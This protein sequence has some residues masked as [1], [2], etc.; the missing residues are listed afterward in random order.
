L[1]IATFAEL[2]PE[3]VERAHRMV[4]CAVATVDRRGRP[5]TRVLHPLWEAGG[6]WITTYRDSPKAGHL[7]ATP[8]ASLAYVAD[9]ARPA[10]AD[11]RAEWVDDPGERRRVWELFAATPPPL[12]FDPVPIYGSPQHPRF[13]LLRLVPWR[14]K[15]AD[16]SGPDHYRI[17]VADG[18][19]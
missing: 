19:P 4:W 18:R 2:E 17:W 13:G 3:L 14:V 10:Y 11:C 1:R 8:Y 9:V 12:G 16:T 15:L 5:T 7:A 6:A